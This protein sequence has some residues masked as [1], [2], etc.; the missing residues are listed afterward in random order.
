MIKRRPMRQVFV[1]NRKQVQWFPKLFGA[2]RRGDIFRLREITGEDVCDLIGRR[3][4]ICLSIEPFETQYELGVDCC[5]IEVY[6]GTAS[7][8]IMDRS[9]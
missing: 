5:S 7:W 1:F 6:D 3:V 4:F 2:L 9:N 8:T